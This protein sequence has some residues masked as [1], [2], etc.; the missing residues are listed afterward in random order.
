MAPA[1]EYAAQFKDGDTDS[2]HPPAGAYRD[3]KA[4]SKQRD[5]VFACI[6]FDDAESAVQE[7]KAAGPSVK[8]QPRRVAWVSEYD[9][10][11]A[12][13]S[14]AE[15]R[16]AGART[17]KTN[18]DDV[19]GECLTQA[20][21]LTSSKEEKS[22]GVPAVVSSGG[23]LSTYAADF[24]GISASSPSAP[25][26]SKI[27]SYEQ[28]SAGRQVAECMDWGEVK[29]ADER[30]PR[31][32]LGAVLQSA[33]LHS[34]DSACNMYSTYEWDYRSR[35]ADDGEMPKPS[36]E[37]RRR[38]SLV[39]ADAA[40]AAETKA[41]A[42]G[43]DDEWV[44][45]EKPSATSEDKGLA[46]NTSNKPKRA[47]GAPGW[48]SLSTGKDSVVATTYDWDFNGKWKEIR[49]KAAKKQQSR[50]AAKRRANKK[51]KSMSRSAIKASRNAALAGVRKASSRNPARSPQATFTW[52]IKPCLCLRRSLHTRLTCL[53]P[54]QRGCLRR[55]PS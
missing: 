34:G 47:I 49:K 39:A 38:L 30:I 52:P 15:T 43:E 53:R 19:V 54:Q 3:N 45:L 1:S 50:E 35:A 6:D 5:Q 4:A 13:M 2:S 18:Y 29:Q 10:A 46:A 14:A 41:A 40:A 31:E 24:C 17:G 25:V 11:F 44:L 28:N 48:A 33:R 27:I 51:K 36:L 55:R 16:R 32:R 23:V 8:P 12:G 21:D 9:A 26:Q 20:A 37:A 7:A 22:S 42:S